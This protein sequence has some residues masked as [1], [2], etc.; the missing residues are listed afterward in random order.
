MN[1]KLINQ[2]CATSVWGG[3]GGGAESYAELQCAL[4]EL[5]RTQLKVTEWKAF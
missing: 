3:G 4:A 1:R 5:R 2:V